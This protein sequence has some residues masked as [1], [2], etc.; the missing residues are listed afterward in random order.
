M[1]CGRNRHAVTITENL[2]QRGQPCLEA[3]RD[4]QTAR[5]PLVL[6]TWQRVGGKTDHFTED[7]FFSSLF[8][9]AHREL[10]SFLIKG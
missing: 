10:N 8:G 3:P 1:D 4:P 2:R 7:C 9:S 5:R 6:L